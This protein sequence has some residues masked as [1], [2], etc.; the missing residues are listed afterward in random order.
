[1]LFGKD[2]R[3]ITAAFP[4]KKKLLYTKGTG[5]AVP[6]RIEKM[7]ALAPEVRFFVIPRAQSSREHVSNFLGRDYPFFT[8]HHGKVSRRR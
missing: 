2:K 6:Y 3:R 4:A 1:M 7:R 5:L 8:N